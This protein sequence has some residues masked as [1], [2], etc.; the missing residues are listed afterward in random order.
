MQAEQAVRTCCA[1][2]GAS[3]RERGIVERLATVQA[4]VTA[5]ER[6]WAGGRTGARGA[7]WEPVLAQ[8]IQLRAGEHE[9]AERQ[10]AYTERAILR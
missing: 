8:G 9:Y 3:E 4:E 6:G 7:A 1:R 5:C 10:R 2:V